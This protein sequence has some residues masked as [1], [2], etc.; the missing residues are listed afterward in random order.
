MPPPNP[1]PVASTELLL[2]TRLVRSTDDIIVMLYSVWFL[3]VDKE[4]RAPPP[5]RSA[6]QCRRTTAV[7]KSFELTQN[8]GSPVTGNANQVTQVFPPARL[9][10]NWVDDKESLQ[11]A[12][13][14]AVPT[15]TYSPPP[16]APPRESVSKTSNTNTSVTVEAEEHRQSLRRQHDTYPSCTPFNL[17]SGVVAH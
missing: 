17:T 6:E 16:A 9:L 4:M 13:P 15:N 5:P 11:P 3:E 8:R 10:R 1:L 7:R 14:E 2:T 12:G